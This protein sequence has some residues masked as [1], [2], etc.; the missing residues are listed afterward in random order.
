MTLSPIAFVNVSSDPVV[1]FIVLFDP[2]LS[3]KSHISLI[4]SKI[5]KSLYILKTAKNI[6]SPKALKSLYYSPVHSHLV[7][8]IQICS[9]GY[10][11]LTN[12][13]F[14]KEKQRSK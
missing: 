4:S 9:C 13:L 3:F 14:T 6:L 11:N 1:K 12:S 10:Q 8:C 2:L 7:Y 5:Y